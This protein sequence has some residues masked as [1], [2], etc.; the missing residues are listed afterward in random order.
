MQTTIAAV[1]AA[2]VLLGV[3]L[4]VA[5]VLLVNAQAASS[6]QDRADNLA[7]AVERREDAGS[8]VDEAL[9]RPY[10]E[11]GR[12]WEARVE[13][14]SED[15]SGVVVGSQAATSAVGESTTVDGSVVRV[16]VPRTAVIG[17]ASQVVL[18]VVVAS[19]VALAAGV[20]VAVVQARRLTQPLVVLAESAERLGAGQLRAPPPASGVPEVDLVAREIARSAQAMAARIA[21]ERQFASDASHQL[22]TPL[23]ALSMRLEEI[24]A[25]TDPVEAASEAQVALDQVERLVAVVDD[26]LGRSRRADSGAAPQTSLHDVLA[27]QHTEWTPAF[28]AAG[29]H[30]SVRVSPELRVAARPGPLAQALATLLENSLVHGGGTTSVSARGSGPSVVLEVSDEGE[31]VPPHLGSR[32]FERSVSSAHSTGL[33]LSLARDLVAAEGGR[34]ELLKHRPPVFAVFLSRG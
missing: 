31:G 5:G 14:A 22:R 13:V 16:E 4:A 7:E 29:R 33:G 2:V 30:L 12:Q 25:A 34:L 1:A 3:P 17:L 15:G 9:V 19:L 27:Q 18:L 6:A 28:V 11:E 26:L 32:I 8:E 20:V 10:A 21:A 23:T 24:V